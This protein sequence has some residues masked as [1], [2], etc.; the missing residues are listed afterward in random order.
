MNYF[1]SEPNYHPTNFLS[2]NLLATKMRTVQI[3]MN[4]RIYLGLF[5]IRI[6]KN[7]NPQVLV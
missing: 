4:T 5:Q 2:V 1:V 7:N 3:I 6:K